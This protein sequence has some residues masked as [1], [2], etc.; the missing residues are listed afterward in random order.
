MKRVITESDVYKLLQNGITHYD[1]DEN[2]I[3]TDLAYE[4]AQKHH[5][6]ISS[7]F[8]NFYH[9]DQKQSI[10]NKKTD[11]IIQDPLLLNEKL[12]ELLK[13]NHE[14]F[15][16]GLITSTGGNVSIRDPFNLQQLWITP[17]SIHKGELTVDMIV[18]ID[19]DGNP[20]NNH[21]TY[22]AS[23]EKFV[24][25]EV[26]KAR[27]DFNAV[28]HTHASLATVLGLTGIPFLPI[29]TDSAF[30]GE[31]T[32]VPF[33]SPGSKDLGTAVAEAMREGFA[34]IMQ[35]HG[36]VVAGK[37]LRFAADMTLIIEST[38]KKILASYMV[39]KEPL[40]IP[41][42]AVEEYKKELK[43]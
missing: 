1:L 28:I 10:P 39:G 15:L 29:S 20:A 22:K 32:R 33:I 37:S 36:L 17:G 41:F 27:P 19:L 9:A 11:K 13:I 18:P 5:I 8:F 35:N 43:I 25:C 30:I 12:T 7:P 31:I 42:N 6:T 21:L 23:S 38:A 16:A 24:H 3:L 40:Q 26:L 14:L 2:T 4:L 34:V